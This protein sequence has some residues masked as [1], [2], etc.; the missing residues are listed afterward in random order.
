MEM[1]GDKIGK[2]GGKARKLQQQKESHNT[3]KREERYRRKAGRQKEVMRVKT[4]RVSLYMYMKVRMFLNSNN[5][6]ARLDTNLN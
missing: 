6:E 5:N 3:L 4:T 1:L 2:A